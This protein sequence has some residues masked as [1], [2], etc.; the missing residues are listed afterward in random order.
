MDPVWPAGPDTGVRAPAAVGT[1]PP[2]TGDPIA[3]P[4]AG[5]RPYGYTPFTWHDHIRPLVEQQCQLC[6]AR[7]PRFGATFPLVA[8]E[9]TIALHAE[10]RPVHEIVA[11][12]VADHAHPMPPRSRPPLNP[13]EIA[14][15][16]S[17]SEG[18]APAGT[19]PGPQDPMQ[20]TPTWWRDIEPI[21][22]NR[23]ALCHGNPVNYGGPMSLV[24]YADLH[25][26]HRSGEAM[27]QVVAFRIVAPQNRMPP[28]TQPQLTSEEVTLVQRWSMAGAPEGDRASAPDAGVVVAPDAGPPDSGPGV[29][30]LDGGAS[31]PSE[32]PSHE[33]I[34]TFAFGRNP[35]ET[36]EVATGDTI[37]ECWSFPVRTSTPTGVN[38]V[39]FEPILHN[40]S[41][42]HHMMLFHDDSGMDR[43]D[44]PF[45]P[46]HCPGFPTK[47]DGTASDMIGGWFPARPPHAMPA[48]V[49]MNLRDGDR[50]ILQGHYDSVRGRGVFDSSGIRVL[51]D[52]SARSYQH[53]STLWSGVIWS[54]PL[55]GYEFRE[56]SCIIRQR[57][58]I[59]AA[60]P[61]LHVY[62]LRIIS[63]VRRA[64]TQT[65]VP[66]AVL[67]PWHFEDQ[68]ILDIDPANQVLNP[69]DELRTR[70]W[71]DTRGETVWQGEGSE[72]EMCFTT[73][74][75]YPVHPNRDASPGGCTVYVP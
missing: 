51:V 42:L 72:D 53:A 41:N 36:Y 73:F 63:D 52:T 44:Q 25:V 14:M 64:G 28:P 18:G 30:W 23:C 45:G 15:F 13:D 59:F 32:Q 19:L 3:A 61:H 7:P 68:P 58:T 9:D 2:A 66:V 57:T 75:H 62:G 48:G 50:L 35:T 1:P 56:G 39:Y 65:W 37:Y 71:W 40:T 33:W 43:R 34:D 22:R 21:M 74:Y 38:A 20:N 47:A 10:G 11:E 70:C 29:P 6:H 67:D 31:P 60:F 4:D 8:Y 54:N 17:W 16:V 26:A 27:H 55:N 46:Y 49:A 24:D 12:R 69:G 5:R